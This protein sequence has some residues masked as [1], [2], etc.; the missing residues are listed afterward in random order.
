[1][2]TLLPNKNQQQDE[3]DDDDQEIG[4]YEIGIAKTYKCLW[5][6]VKLPAV[7]S[8]ILIL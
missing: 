6:V 1:M 5:A 8:L 3:E 2:E 4:V 7:Q